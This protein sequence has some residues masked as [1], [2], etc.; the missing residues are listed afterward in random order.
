MH[1]RGE[2]A[3][4]VHGL[5]VRKDV[6]PARDAAARS[7]RADEVD[8]GAEADGRPRGRH[9]LN[10]TEHAPGMRSMQQPFAHP[11]SSWSCWVPALRH[12]SR[13]QPMS[14]SKRPVNSRRRSSCKSAKTTFRTPRLLATESGRLADTTVRD[15]GDASRASATARHHEA[16]DGPQLRP[17]PLLRCTSTS[18]AHGLSSRRIARRP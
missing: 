5:P 12:R 17:T 18:G 1:R 11:P 10:E 14:R 4:T 2:A 6:Y 8:A 15:F 7:S 3:E 13:R 9:D 16:P